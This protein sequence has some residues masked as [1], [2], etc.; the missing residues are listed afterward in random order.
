MVRKCFISF[1]TEDV[2]YKNYIQNI[3]NISMID[4]SLNTPILSY[5]EDYIMSKIREKHLSN[6]TVTIHLIGTK[7][8]EN[9]GWN[10]QKYIKR[11]LQASLYNGIGNTKNGILGVVLPSMYD[12]IYGATY[13]CS[14]CGSNHNYV[15]INDL[16]V[17]K[18]F[19][20]NYYIQN[21]SN[22]KCSWV[23][24]EKYCVLVKWNDFIISPKN[25]IEQAFKKR[26]HPISKNT[27]VRP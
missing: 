24:D 5:D 4:N 27:K 9:L 16:T 19:S 21:A 8:S 18:E 3:L 25:F 15:G 20:A 17:V 13:V 23:E 7:S 1:K 22:N 10:E 14:E 6:S 2:A 11:E 26:T 12:Q